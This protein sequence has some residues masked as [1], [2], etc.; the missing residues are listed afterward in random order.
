MK[1][2]LPKSFFDL[3]EQSD[4]PVVVDFGAPWCA[5]CRM[6]SPALERLATE[7]K[8]KLVVVKINV[9]E[10]QHI[11][12]RYQ[13]QSIP[14]IMMFHKGNTL[15]RLTGALPYESIRQEVITKLK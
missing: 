10:K 7:F 8:G 6:V 15:M 4:V 2:K 12:G 11:A 1:N 13:I 3:I 5:P 14:T 9:D